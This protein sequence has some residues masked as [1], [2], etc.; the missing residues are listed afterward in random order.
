MAS[1][2]S[3]SDLA[4]KPSRFASKGRRFLQSADIAPYH[5]SELQ[6]A[7]ATLELKNGKVRRSRK[8]FKDSLVEPNDNVVAQVDWASRQISEIDIRQE[9]LS[10]A[11]MFEVQSA[12]AYIDGDWDVSIKA[13]LEWFADDPLSKH[14]V[15]SAAFVSSMALADHVTA[16]QLTLLAMQSHGHDPLLLNEQALYLAL[17][18]RVEEAVTIY[19]L[20]NKQLFTIENHITH[21]ATGGMILFRSGSADQGREAY[22]NAI[23]AAKARS[24]SWYVSWATLLLAHEEVHARTAHSVEALE[25]LDKVERPFDVKAFTALE[26]RIRGQQAQYPLIEYPN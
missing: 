6:A 8:L 14:S 5:L 12:R 19:N 20:Q 17:Q 3:V 15:R 23:E 9:L 11:N 24:L 18:G 2:I 21:L 13:S 16:E 7:I 4:D 1:E 26:E 22:L 10:R 25:R